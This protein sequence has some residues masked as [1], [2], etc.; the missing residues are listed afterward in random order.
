MKNLC[1]NTCKNFKFFSV[2]PCNADQESKHQKWKFEF[3]N[4]HYT[5]DST[6]L[7]KLTPITILDWHR[8][9]SIYDIPFPPFPDIV[10]RKWNTQYD[11]LDEEP[12]G[13]N[14]EDTVG[15]PHTTSMAH[16]RH[17]VID[18]TKHT[19]SAHMTH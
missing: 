4:P 18:A 14:L 16:C 12:E 1:S 2:G 17:T 8:N 19:L 3:Y 11:T 13:K 10:L 5:N 9:Y 7:T 6:K 15:D